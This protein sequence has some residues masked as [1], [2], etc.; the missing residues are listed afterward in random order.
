MVPWEPMEPTMVPM[1]TGVKREAKV[2]GVVFM[3]P[4]SPR[5]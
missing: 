2:P 4:V 3:L 1:E 5:V